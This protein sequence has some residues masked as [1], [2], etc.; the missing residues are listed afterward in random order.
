MASPTIIFDSTF[1]RGSRV[2]NEP[3]WDEPLPGASLCAWLQLWTIMPWAPPKYVPKTSDFLR[4]IDAV[5][6][7]RGFPTGKDVF[8][9]YGPAPYTSQTNFGPKTTP[10]S[11]QLD[12]ETTWLDRMPANYYAD[13]ITAIR[14]KH[15][16]IRLMT[17]AP[18][19]LQGFDDTPLKKQVWIPDN[20]TLD[21]AKAYAEQNKAWIDQLW[22]LVLTCYFGS[23][24]NDQPAIWLY[25]NM[26]KLARLVFPG[27]RIIIQTS[28]QRNESWYAPGGVLSDAITNQFAGVM[29]SAHPE[30]MI[31]WGLRAKNLKMFSAFGINPTVPA[32]LLERASS[33]RLVAPSPTVISERN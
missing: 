15:P 19:P 21:G 9:F 20:A 4:V 30:G 18:N 17:F 23:P 1:W 28:A 26:I 12:W 25:Y 31:I 2:N 11:F 29:R 16:G 27:R 7:K 32:T 14:Q 3:V 22:G 24:H 13:I 8:R 10:H 6:A 33:P 5:L